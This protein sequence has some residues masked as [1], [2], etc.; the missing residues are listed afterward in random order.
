MIRVPFCWSKIMEAAFQSGMCLDLSMHLWKSAPHLGK[1][2][3]Y[4][5][6]LYLNHSKTE[7]LVITLKKV[8]NSVKQAA[9]SF[10]NKL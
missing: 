7:V 5:I 3:S 4:I 9:T 1:V 6:A 2:L 10:E 8:V